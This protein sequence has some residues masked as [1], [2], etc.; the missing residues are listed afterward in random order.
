M[1][2]L[3]VIPGTILLIYLIFVIQ[4]LRDNHRERKRNLEKMRCKLL[5]IEYIPPYTDIDWW[6]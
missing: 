5:G 2:P 6:P 3:L 1:K 4:Q